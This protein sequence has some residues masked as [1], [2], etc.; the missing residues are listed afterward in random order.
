MVHTALANGGDNW[1]W[2]EYDMIL[3][4]PPCPDFSVAGMRH[5][6]KRGKV[7]NP[8]TVGSI[9]LVK[10]ILAFCHESPGLWVMENPRGMLRKVIGRPK[11]TSF[12]CWSGA[13]WMKPTDI[14]GDFPGSL[15]LPCA[16]HESASRSTAEGFQSRPGQAWGVASRLIRGRPTP[17]REGFG[18]APTDGGDVK[19]CVPCGHEHKTTCRGDCL[20]GES[21]A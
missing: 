15:R 9:E 14:W 20:S 5:H 8:E 11:E 18:A 3:A 10:E 16:P 6:W 2:G 17:R 12:M 19:V 7:P 13:P 4:S 21:A 1:S